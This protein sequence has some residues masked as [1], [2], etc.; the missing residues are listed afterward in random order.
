MLNKNRSQQKFGAKA[1]A[2][3]CRCFGKHHQE[4]E[5]RHYDFKNKLAMLIYDV[6]NL[7]LH[8][9]AILPAAIFDFFKFV[10]KL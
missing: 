6:K 4:I 1:K 5:L 2:S 10:F 7:Q 8:L 9:F 3:N